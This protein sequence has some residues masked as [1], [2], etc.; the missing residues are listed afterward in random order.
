MPVPSNPVSWWL[1]AE[2]F[3]LPISCETEEHRTSTVLRNGGDSK[4]S[5]FPNRS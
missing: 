2:K 1:V 4:E 3:K 5:V